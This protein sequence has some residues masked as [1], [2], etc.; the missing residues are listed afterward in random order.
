MTNP[1]TE[2]DPNSLAELFSRDPLSLSDADI[3][4]IVAEYRK[5]R[6]IWQ[7]ADNQGKPAPRKPAAPKIKQST[8]DA[9]K[10][11]GL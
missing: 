10:E 5:Q 4:K 3:D 11:L 1:I 9:L 6:E 2:A 7:L 8:E